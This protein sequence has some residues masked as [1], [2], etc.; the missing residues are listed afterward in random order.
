[1]SLVWVYALINFKILPV[2]KSK[3]ESLFSISKATFVGRELL[4][5]IVLHCLLKKSL[6]KF[7]FAKTSVTSRLP[8]NIGGIRGIL[9]PFTKVFKIDL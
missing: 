7:A 8:A 9:E 4:L 3:V 1:M 5:T 2:L 6:S